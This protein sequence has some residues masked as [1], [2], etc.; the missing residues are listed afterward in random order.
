MCNLYRIRTARAEVARMF[1]ASD[2]DG[3]ELEKDYVSSGR[4]GLVVRASGELRALEAMTWGWPNPRGGRPV[5]NVRNYD[6]PFWRSALNSPERRCLVPFTEFQEWTSSPDPLTGKKQAHWFSVRS[7]PVAA[8]AGI[9]R[10]SDTGPI[11]AFLTTGYDGDPANHLVG[12]IHPQAIPVVLHDEDHDRWLH[13]PVAEALALA[14]AFP[15]QLMAV[16]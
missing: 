16:A 10:P 8:L 13:A 1:A 3:T 2:V 15:S 6:S 9:W 7:R 12:A 4:K 5:V 14:T 11:F